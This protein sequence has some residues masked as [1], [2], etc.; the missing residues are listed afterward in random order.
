MEFIYKKLCVYSYMF[1]LWSPSKC[2]PFDATHLSRCF[3][4]CSKQFLHLS[5]LIPFSASAVFG[6]TCSLSAK[7][8]PLRTSSSRKT[9]KEV[10]QG[11][12]QVNRKG[13]TWGSCHF[14]SK[15]AEPSM[16]CGQVHSQT[17]LHEM[18]PNAASH[19]TSCALTD[20]DGFLEHSPSR[21]SLYYK[22]LTLQKIILVLGGP[23]SY[24]ISYF[25]VHIS[26]NGHLG[27]LHSFFLIKR[28]VR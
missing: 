28:Y 9:K 13:G 24:I 22:G 17:T 25:L 2:S 3:S 7:C 1:E 12:D 21:G 27:Y 14:W 19:N 26:I 23:P 10:S 5:I 6:F 18:K 4:Y 16:R 11:P 15:I 8:F 20:T